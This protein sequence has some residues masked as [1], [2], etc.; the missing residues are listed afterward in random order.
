MDYY[1]DADD[2]DILGQPFSSRYDAMAMADHRCRMTGHKYVVY[3]G[4]EIIYTARPI[5]KP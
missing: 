4:G 3:D 1:G 5:H 2:D